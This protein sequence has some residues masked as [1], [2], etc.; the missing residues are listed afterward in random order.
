MPV[1]FK[2]IKKENESENQ[3]F[4]AVDR[5]ICEHFQVPVDKHSYYNDWYDYLGLRFA[6]GWTFEKIKTDID[7]CMKNDVKYWSRMDEVLEF[8]NERFCWIS[9][10][11]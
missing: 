7:S 9:W 11:E 4:A 1:C 6:V 8:L 5:E 3:P 10:R 2:L